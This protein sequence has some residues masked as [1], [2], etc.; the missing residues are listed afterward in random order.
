MIL[1]IWEYEFE[2]EATCQAF[3]D[4]MTALLSEPLGRNLR[5][6]LPISVMEDLSPTVRSNTLLFFATA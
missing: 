2:D 5:I 4:G 3:K 6:W 1:G